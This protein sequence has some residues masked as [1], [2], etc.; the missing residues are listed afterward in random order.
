[1]MFNLAQEKIAVDNQLHDPSVTPSGMVAYL[2]EWLD[3][4]PVVAQSLKKY[5][6]IALADLPY[7]VN[8]LLESE[9]PNIGNLPATA[10]NGKTFSFDLGELKVR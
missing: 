4:H 1:M 6:A 8:L 5:L 7:L 10:L 3:K 9:I 2:R